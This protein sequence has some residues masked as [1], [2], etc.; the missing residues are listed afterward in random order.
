MILLALLSLFT[1]SVASLP[2]ADNTPRV[3]DGFAVANPIGLNQRPFLN[4]TS[5]STTNAPLKRHTPDIALWNHMI[6]Y[7][8]NKK[9][10]KFSP[11]EETVD[12]KYPDGTEQHIEH[13]VDPI[14]VLESVILPD[15]S[16]G[17]AGV[18][19]ES[20]ASID[21]EKHREGKAKVTDECYDP[22]REILLKDL[23]ALSEDIRRI[24]NL[25]K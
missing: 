14:E 21:L 5:Q 1:V 9:E 12:V 11:E 22:R 25:L 3:R 17:V 23:E 7:M 15:I 16:K 6:S 4:Q 10:I 18:E 13:A 8:K 20:V 24:Q 2:K 19:A